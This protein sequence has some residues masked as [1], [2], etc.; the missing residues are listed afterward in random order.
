MNNPESIDEKATESLE[1]ALRDFPY[2]A[3]LQQLYL[4]GLENQKSYLA[5]AQLK[6]A[7]MWSPNRFKLKEWL[8]IDE[9]LSGKLGDIPEP[10]K[11]QPQPKPT[12]PPPQ[13]TSPKPQEKKDENPTVEVRKEQPA[14]KPIEVPKPTPPPAPKKSEST[15]EAHRTQLGDDLSHLP[16]KVREIVEKSRRLKNQYGGTGVPIPE[17]APEKVER[18]EIPPVEQV[19][20]EA[21]SEPET[22]EE[23]IKE[24]AEEQAEIA[25]TF[26]EQVDTT[27]TEPIE[28]DMSGVSLP[29][30]LDVDPVEEDEEVEERTFARPIVLDELTEVSRQEEAVELDFTA[31]LRMKAGRSEEPVEE[32]TLE[33]VSTDIQWSE[34]AES[35]A[36]KEPVVEVEEEKKADSKLKKMQLIDKFIE[37]QPK[38]S[39]MKKS[40]NVSV[41]QYEKPKRID[42]SAMGSEVGDDFITE[43][44]AQVYKQQ[45]ALDKALSAYEILRLKYPEK[46][47]FFADQISEIRRLLRKS[48]N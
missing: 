15:V 38:I 8:E 3:V 26:D 43:T 46:S 31:W 30:L 16:P 48:G 1:G 20:K 22:L 13:V 44:L 40:E 37:D 27:E 5:T 12:P 32:E 17:E 35:A 25:P 9:D 33:E 21:P 28:I 18:P 6:K 29:P 11:R 24:V 45:G 42:V 7:A 19:R 10:P 23:V 39:P 47:S 14:P 41:N 4:R 2:S 34:V 36:E